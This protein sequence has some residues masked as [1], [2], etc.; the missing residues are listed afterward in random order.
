[1]LADYDC[2]I[3]YHPEKAN[4]VANTLSR[5]EPRVSYHLKSMTLFVIPGIIE[6]LRASRRV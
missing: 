3:S 4:V 6:R 2:E 1:M 5:K